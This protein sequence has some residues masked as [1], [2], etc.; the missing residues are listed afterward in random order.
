MEDE[1]DMFNELYEEKAI[2]L[3]EYNE[4]ENSKYSPPFLEYA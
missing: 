4:K 3:I 1:D 2:P